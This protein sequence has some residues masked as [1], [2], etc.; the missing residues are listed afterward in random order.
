MRFYGLVGGA[1]FTASRFAASLFRRRDDMSD[2]SYGLVSVCPFRRVAFTPQLLRHGAQIAAAAK[3]DAAKRDAAKRDAAKR[4]PTNQARGLGVHIITAEKQLR[5][6]RDTAKW[7][8]A[9]QATA[10]G[11]HII[12]AAKNDAAKQ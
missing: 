12:T 5:G 10:T 1:Y 2:S 6:E 3:Y 11:A 7:V 9:D 4:A 8:H